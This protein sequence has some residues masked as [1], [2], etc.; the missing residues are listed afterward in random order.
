MPLVQRRLLIFALSYNDIIVWPVS[1]LH[2]STLRAE[3]QPTLCV[4][5]WETCLGPNLPPRA[6]PGFRASPP[7]QHACP[8]PVACP[9]RCPGRPGALPVA[10]PAHCCSLPGWSQTRRAGTQSLVVAILQAGTP[11]QGG[12]ER[13]NSRVSVL[14]GAAQVDPR[15]GGSCRAVVGRGGDG[16]G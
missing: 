11:G 2:L 7:P 15:R 14:T 4:S 10:W 16:S 5:V 1:S 3:V 6:A 9:A 8:S 13:K 12:L